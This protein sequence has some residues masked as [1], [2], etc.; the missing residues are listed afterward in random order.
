MF[1]QGADIS[2]PPLS[3]A[4][5][6]L[7]RVAPG[8]LER[9]R[10]QARR[11][12]VRDRD[13]TDAGAALEAL[14]DLA[15]IDIDVPTASRIRAAVLVKQAIK[16]LIGWYLGYFG[17]QLA[18]FGQAVAHL[19]EMMLRRIVAVEDSTQRLQ[20][21]VR[22]LEERVARLEGLLDRSERR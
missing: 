17:R 15:D 19:C 8:Y 9:V 20:G 22:R 10:D 21:E 4:A 11:L 1:R 18:A 14:E 2:A 3:A 13:G 5:A 6:E 7:A 12:S 16:R